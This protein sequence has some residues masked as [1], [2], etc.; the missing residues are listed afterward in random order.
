LIE[1]SPAHWH[2]TGGFGK[3]GQLGETKPT[4]IGCVYIHSQGGL[5][6]DPHFN[7][8]LAAIA[9]MHEIYGERPEDHPTE[10]HV[11]HVSASADALVETA[12]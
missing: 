2:V 7:E 9:G 8:Y 4:R 3:L 11:D 5:I 6:M 12:S 1:V 10:F